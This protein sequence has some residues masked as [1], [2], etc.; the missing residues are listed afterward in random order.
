VKDGRTLFILEGKYGC[1]GTGFFT[2][3]LRF[4][5]DTPDHH[6]QIEDDADRM[7]FFSRTKCVDEE[8]G[9]AMLNIM[10]KTGKIYSPLWVSGAVIVS[11]DLLLSIEDAYKK[12]NNVIIT[13]NEIIY[14][15]EQKGVSGTGNT[16]TTELPDTETGC[17]GVSGPDNTQRKEK[18]RKEKNIYPVS[19]EEFWKAYPKHTAKKGAFAEWK[20]AEATGLL[21]SIDALLSAIKD[22]KRA[23]QRALDTG[24][25]A[26]E[27]PDPERWI[28]KARWEDEVGSVESVQPQGTR[29]SP[30]VKCP[31]C[32]AEVLDSSLDPDGKGCFKCIGGD[33]PQSVA[34]EMSRRAGA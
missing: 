1:A 21:P 10:A 33:I 3:V 22:Q 34:E 13:L 6:F 14:H 2:N 31:R 5:C 23:K 26:S 15:Y 8:A 11:P 30:Y 12:R 18:K 32:G 7:F 27:W 29:A 17:D 20:K 25:F 4:L 19:F 24:Q 28:K 9:M 16:H